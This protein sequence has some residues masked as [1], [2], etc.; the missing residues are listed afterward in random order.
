[1]ALRTCG[2]PSRRSSGEVMGNKLTKAER[3]RLE[4]NEIYFITLANSRASFAYLPVMAFVN[5]LFLSF[6]TV[7]AGATAFLPGGHRAFVVLFCVNLVALG[8]SVLVLLSS[9]FRALIYRFQV[10]FSRVMAVSAAVMVYALCLAGV[11]LITWVDHSGFTMF[12]A[13]LFPF[14]GAV[15]LLYLCG[16]TVVHVLLLRKRLRDGH[17]EERTWGN[18]AAASSVYSSKSMWI[19]FGAVTIVPNLL[20]QGEYMKATFGV[21]YFLFM[22]AVTPSLPVEFTYLAYLKSRDKRYW[23]ERPAKRRR[24]K[25]QAR[26]FFK[27]IALWV[28]IFIAVCVAFGTLAKIL[29]G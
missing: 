1:M 10:F 5:A 13:T 9:F 25:G 3:A 14:V 15:G 27:K 23:D 22:G 18:V 20:T 21:I 7:A 29:E 19:I 24:K 6:F 16:A 11:L 8:F 4:A 28:G 26:A 2:T 17:S 12:D